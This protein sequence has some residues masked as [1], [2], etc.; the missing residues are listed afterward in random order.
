MDCQALRHRLLTAMPPR[1]EEDPADPSKSWYLASS[2]ALEW[3]EPT[4]V[5]EDRSLTRSMLTGSSRWVGRA[6]AAE[7]PLALRFAIPNS[8]YSRA[9]ARETLHAEVLRAKQGVSTNMLSVLN[10]AAQESTHR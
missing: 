3:C 9:L 10:H 1:G 5:Q 7:F 8:K 2:A 4:E 6:V